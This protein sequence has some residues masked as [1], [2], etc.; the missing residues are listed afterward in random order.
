[1]TSVFPR[2]DLSIRQ[3]DIQFAKRNLIFYVHIEGL[4]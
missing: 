3:Y 1:M 2:K 4:S